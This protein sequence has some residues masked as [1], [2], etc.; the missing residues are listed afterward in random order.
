MHPRP[1]P[2]DKVPFNFAPPGINPAG[3]AP[4]SAGGLLG[5][6]NE[7]MREGTLTSGD[8][9]DSNTEDTSQQTNQI[10]ERRLGRRTYRV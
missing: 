8:D 6:Y 9:L 3:A 4:E 5:M 10:P 2:G 7:M 1:A